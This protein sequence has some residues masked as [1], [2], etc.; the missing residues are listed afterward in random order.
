MELQIILGFVP[1]SRGWDDILRPARRA[2]SLRVG[3]LSDAVSPA[4]RAG[5]GPT[6]RYLFTPGNVTLVVTVALT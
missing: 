5:P 4:P 6:G 2:G 1:Q 3:P